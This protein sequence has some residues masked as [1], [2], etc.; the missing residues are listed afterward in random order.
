MT[1]DMSQV[2]LDTTQTRKN[3]FQNVSIANQT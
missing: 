1:S 3:P 2:A